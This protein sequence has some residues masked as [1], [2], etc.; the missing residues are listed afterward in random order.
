[1][2]TWPLIAVLALG[3]LSASQDQKDPS[4][5]LQK[6]SEELRKAIKTA[7]KDL[8][9]RQRLTKLAKSTFDKDLASA[10]APASPKGAWDYQ[11]DFLDHLATADTHFRADTDKLE[12]ALW[13]AACKAAYTKQLS[14]AKEA[15]AGADVPA[16]DQVYYDLTQAVASVFKRFARGSTEYDQA[17]YAGAKQAFGMLLP[18]SKTAQGDPKVLYTKWLSDIDRVYPLTTDDQKKQNTLPN[19]LLKAASKS[20]LDRMLAAPK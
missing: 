16:P 12:R 13:I 17:G 15:A 20:A 5:L 2:T 6:L 18:K 1:M 14:S 3:G 8:D 4:E 9:V 11:S 19:Q 7:G 10:P